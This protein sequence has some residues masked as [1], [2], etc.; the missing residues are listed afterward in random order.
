MPVWHS[1]FV[2]RCSC[3]TSSSGREDSM[4]CRI[5]W[6][7]L[8]VARNSALRWV[9]SV[10]ILFHLVIKV[11]LPLRSPSLLGK[12]DLNVEVTLLLRLIFFSVTQIIYI[13]QN[14]HCLEHITNTINHFP[15]H[16]KQAYTNV[17]SNLT[18]LSPWLY[19]HLVIKVSTVPYYFCTV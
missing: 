9:F 18:R 16:E 19:S 5:S 13:L 12:S 10:S 14:E 3:R 8:A 15:W 7:F 6:T 4:R 17:Q 2:N 1:L 11:I